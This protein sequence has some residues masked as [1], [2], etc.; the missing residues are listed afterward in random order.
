MTHG[1]VILLRLLNRSDYY[2][3]QLDRIIE[4]NSIR[5]WADI[6]FS[7][8]Y[9]I[10]NKMEKK[11]YVGSRF[12]KEYGSPRRKVYFITEE[13]RIELS[14]EVK[15][16]LREPAELHDDFTV[17]IVVSDVLNED[18]FARCLADY[19]KHLSS[20]L[21]FLEKKLPRA[22]REKEHVMLAF[23]RVRHLTE[24]EIRWIDSL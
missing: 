18:D 22:V 19:R 6:G 23:D 2:G 15:R 14:G 17:G 16:M 8:I 11:G 20:R 10:L 5:R 3:Y 24:A 9:N 4:E 13:G 7:S 1:E 21:E 12:E